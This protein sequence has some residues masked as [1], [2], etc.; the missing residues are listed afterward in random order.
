MIKSQFGPSSRSIKSKAKELALDFRKAYNAMQWDWGGI[1]S[2]K[3]LLCIEN[4]AHVKHIELVKKIE[5]E[6]VI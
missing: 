3:S 5:N 2:I 1:L 4:T 6:E